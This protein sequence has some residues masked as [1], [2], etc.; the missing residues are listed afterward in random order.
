MRLPYSSL[1]N[2]SFGLYFKVMNLHPVTHFDKF[3]GGFFI[4]PH[5][6]FLRRYNKS[7]PRLT[8]GF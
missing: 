5:A 7:K 2:L 1:I 4:K 6:K 3:M 8:F